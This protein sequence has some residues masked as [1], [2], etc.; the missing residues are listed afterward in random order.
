VGGGGGGSKR[1]CDMSCLDDGTR[2]GWDCTAVNIKLCFC[3][4]DVMY[5]DDYIV[6]SSEDGGSSSFLQYIYTHSPHDTASH[7]TIIMYSTFI[8]DSSVCVPKIQD[9]LR[10]LIDR[11]V[12]HNQSRNSPGHI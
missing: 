12:M 7:S 11:I 10:G 8:K 9:S 5:V 2:L 4:R 1:P 6:F 3:G